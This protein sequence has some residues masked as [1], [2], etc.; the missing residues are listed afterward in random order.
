MCSSYA[1]QHWIL[2]GQPG[3]I[4]DRV[5]SCFV[6]QHGVNDRRATGKEKASGQHEGNTW[7]TANGTIELLHERSD[8]RATGKEKA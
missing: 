7:Q 6:F 5:A 1:A 8:R 2:I 3:N 4:A